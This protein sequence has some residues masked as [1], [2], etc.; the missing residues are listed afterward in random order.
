MGK[1]KPKILAIIPARQGSKQVPGKNIKPLAGK[2]LLAYSIEAARG[3]SGVDRIVVSTDGREI[4]QVSKEWSVEVI[5]RPSELAS[6]LSPTEPVLEHVVQTLGQ[7]EDYI[8]NYIMLL[9]PTS[10]LRPPELLDH[11][12]KTIIDGGYDSLLTV[13]KTPSFLWRKHLDHVEALYDYLKR[14]RRQDI[15]LDQQCF[16]ENGSVYITRTMLLMETHNRLGGKTEMIII[17]EE[18]SLEIDSSFDFWLAEQI[19]CWRNKRE[20]IQ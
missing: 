9:Q 10:P 16:R 7:R 14:P 20:P 17:D 12:I 2:P 1:S 13:S 18:D 15:P 11:C 3:S 5:D 6:D 8:P 4:A 19:L